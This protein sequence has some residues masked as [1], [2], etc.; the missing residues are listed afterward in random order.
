MYYLSLLF[1]VLHYTCNFSYDKNAGNQHVFY[2]LLLILFVKN[3]TKNIILENLN[4]TNPY[5]KFFIPKKYLRELCS[6]ALNYH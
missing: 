1:S 6:N 3:K 2:I 5:S 4:H